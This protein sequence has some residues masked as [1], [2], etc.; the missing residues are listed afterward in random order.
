MSKPHI[1]PALQTYVTI[2]E[3]AIAQIVACHKV[4]KADGGYPP[5]PEVD[6]LDEVIAAANELLE[7]N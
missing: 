5:T 3:Q 1:A 7:H 2:L 6:D 4:V